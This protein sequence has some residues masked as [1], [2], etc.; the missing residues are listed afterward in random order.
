MQKDVVYINSHYVSKHDA[1]I[2]VFDRGFL[3][4][5]GIYEVI[6]VYSGKILFLE[7]HL[8]RLQNSLDLIKINYVVDYNKWSNICQKLVTENYNGESRP[9][10]IQITRGTE[11][12]R[13]HDYAQDTI[14]TEVAFLLPEVTLGL[15]LKT[16]KL[17]VITLPDIRWKHC[18]IKSIG[19]IGNIL[20]RQQGKAQHADEVL[21]LNNDNH[22]V[23]GSYSNFFIVK[24]NTIYTPPCNHEILP[25]ITRR[26]IAKICQEHKIQLI[27]KN[28]TEDD[29]HNADEVWISSS[30]KEIR[31]VT[32][33]NETA[34]NNGKPGPLWQKVASYYIKNIEQQL[35]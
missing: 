23:E 14:P 31:P 28:I 21:L 10:Y 4:A 7:E 8:Q 29:L 3:F 24:N 27:E 26:I 30:T 12:N 15:S 9:I 25:G 34:I 6:P 18:D 35:T 13:Q 11:E 32:Q 2:S 19:L 20:L 5:D 16:K 1:N 33:V 22:V 17:K